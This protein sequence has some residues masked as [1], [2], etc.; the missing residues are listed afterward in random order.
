MVTLTA[1]PNCPPLTQLLGSV[2]RSTFCVPAHRTRPGRFGVHLAE[3]SSLHRAR[4]LPGAAVST[5][6]GEPACKAET[7]PA[8]LR[9]RVH[10]EKALEEQK[11]VSADRDVCSFLFCFIF[12]SIMLSSALIPASLNDLQAPLTIRRYETC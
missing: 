9:T 10:M 12:F 6:Q 3:A 8:S 1:V 5:V 4:S 2:P 11:C 7:R